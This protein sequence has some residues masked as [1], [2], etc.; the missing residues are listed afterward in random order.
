MRVQLV[1]KLSFPTSVPWAEQAKFWDMLSVEKLPMQP[2]VV[3][4]TLPCYWSS[5]ITYSRK[6]WAQG[7]KGWF[8]GRKIEPSYTNQRYSST[9]E[10]SSKHYSALGRQKFVHIYHQDESLLVLMDWWQLDPTDATK[11]K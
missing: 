7:K 1:A 4:F 10:S 11:P 8:E 3:G 6:C 5:R 9:S 2:C